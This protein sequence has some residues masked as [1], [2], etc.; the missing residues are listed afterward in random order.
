MLNLGK[1]TT[2]IVSIVVNIYST[3]GSEVLTNHWLVTL[4]GEGG[5]D[6]AKAVAK[7]T[8]FTYVS[9]VCFRRC[10]VN[11]NLKVTRKQSLVVSC[12][13]LKMNPWKT[14]NHS[15]LYV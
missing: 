14:I 11:S 12:K 10:N 1:W 15:G 2:L 5:I 13:P 4:D 6:A 7:R 8:G 9:P 3:C